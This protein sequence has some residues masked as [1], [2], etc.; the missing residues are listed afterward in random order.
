MGED[1]AGEDRSRERV[2]D[3]IGNC[4]LGEVCKRVHTD[5]RKCGRMI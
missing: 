1:S 2:P 5:E 4:K 3:Q